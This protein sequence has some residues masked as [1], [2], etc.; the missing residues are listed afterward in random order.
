MEGEWARTE[1]LRKLD[2]EMEEVDGCVVEGVTEV[3]EGLKVGIEAGGQVLR[4][5]LQLITSCLLNSFGE[6]H[7][8]ILVRHMA[9]KELLSHLIPLSFNCFSLLNLKK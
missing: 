9:L 8:K 7:N 4:A 2:E 5:A 3:E 1:G 6:S